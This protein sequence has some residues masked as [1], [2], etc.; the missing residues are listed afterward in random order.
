[1]TDNQNLQELWDWTTHGPIDIMHGR[2]FFHFNP[3]L[4]IEKIEP[5]QKMAPESKF[6]ELEVARNSNGDKVACTYY[7]SFFFWC[8]S[9]NITFV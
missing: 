7:H 3:K 2:L 9:H 5:L 6:T 1:M 4:C 8:S